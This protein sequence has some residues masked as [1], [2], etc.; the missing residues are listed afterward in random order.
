DMA[1]MWCHNGAMDLSQYVDDIQRQIAASAETAGGEAVALVERLAGPIAAGI[2]LALIDAL[3]AAAAEITM[4]LAPAVV[5]V[6]M[7]GPDPEFVVA[8]ADRATESSDAPVPPAGDN[9]ARI[10]VRLPEQLKVRL[11]QAASAEGISVN[12]WL[13]RAAW[14]AVERHQSGTRP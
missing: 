4:D 9:D 2:Q 11:E 14:A 8:G 7:G 6:T 13:I 5:E 10:N 3:P 12:S 1:P